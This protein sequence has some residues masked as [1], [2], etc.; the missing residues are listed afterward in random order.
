MYVHVSIPVSVM[1]PVFPASLFTRIYNLTAHPIAPPSATH[2][3][4]FVPE[5]KA[6]TS[7]LH[8]TTPQRTVEPP[9]AG[10]C[11]TTHTLRAALRGF[12]GGDVEI[13]GAAG[14]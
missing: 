14:T 6:T 8:P 13:L 4:G 2:S 1:I 3:S 7:P 5:W 9:S 12:N 11:I 10:A